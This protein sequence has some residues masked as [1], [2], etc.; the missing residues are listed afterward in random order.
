M[1]FGYEYDFGPDV[2]WYLSPDPQKAEFEVWV[3]VKKKQENI[4]FVIDSQ[5]LSI[6]FVKE[7]KMDIGSFVVKISICWIK[8]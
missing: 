4:E 3:P 8:I 1:L 5:Y 7:N 2:E 6:V